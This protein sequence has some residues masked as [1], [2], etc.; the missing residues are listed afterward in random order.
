MKLNLAF[1]LW[2]SSFL[3]EK[4]AIWGSDVMLIFAATAK[5]TKQAAW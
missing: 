4:I 1:D 2:R 5:G 3:Q